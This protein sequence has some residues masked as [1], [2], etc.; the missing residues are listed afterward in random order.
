MTRVAV[1]DKFVRMSS[2]RIM[3]LIPA[4]AGIQE[5]RELKLSESQVPAL[6][7]MSSVPNPNFTA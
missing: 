6:A 2:V 4:H 7:G 3:P 1:S 5:A